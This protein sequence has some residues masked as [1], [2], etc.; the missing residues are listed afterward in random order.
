MFRQRSASLAVANEEVEE[1]EDREAKLE[2]KKVVFANRKK[3]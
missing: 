2:V 3:F 1:N